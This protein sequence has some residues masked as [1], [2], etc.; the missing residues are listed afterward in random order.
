M[1][2]LP[3]MTLAATS[4]AL[5]HGEVTSCQLVEA[6]LARIRQYQRAVNCFIDVRPDNAWQQAEVA[7]REIG[8]RR[9]RG[10]LHGIPL[11]EKDMFFTPGKSSTMG[12]S[13]GHTFVPKTRAT[14]L[15]RIEAAGAVSL[16]TLHMSEFAAGPTG[17][18]EY[19]GSCRNPWNTNYISGGSSSGSACAVAARFVYGSLGS[20][21]GGSIRLP[22]G[23]CGVVGLKPTHGVVSRHGAMPR[24]WSLDIIGPIA[25]TSMDCAVLLQAVAGRD[26]ADPATYPGRGVIAIDQL[27]QDVEALRIG[28]P[29]SMFGMP[30]DSEV[31]SA[32][33]EAAGVLMDIG[34]QVFD[35]DLPATDEIYALTQIVNKAES[36]ALHARWL[37]SQPDA[38]GLSAR[39][40]IEAGFHVPAPFYLAALAARPRMLKE[41][42]EEVFTKVDVLLLPVIPR[43]VPSISEVDMKAAGEV[44]A[45]VDEITQC[46]RWVSYLGLP[47]IAA[48]CGFSRRDLPIS[49]Q[50]L[51]KPYSE[52][53]LL[54][55]V[56]RYQMAT[57]WHER[58]PEINPSSQTSSLH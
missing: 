24:C 4:N 45:I 17:Q 50:L 37:L 35:I 21:T 44:P 39:S 10:P 5:Q 22:A 51:G 54:A 28:L 48:P 14:V 33:K 53:S 40:R 30:H 29:S 9:Y 1:N 3:F 20:D 52:H 34:C 26:E 46:T 31:M 15:D 38:Y 42:G 11:A 41:F 16:G 18:N 55:L 19:L 27:G 43:E 7:D 47:A 6:C 8:A 49:F 25:R 36:A 13:F 23:M 12:S 32:L 56:H 57:A 2:S 58:I